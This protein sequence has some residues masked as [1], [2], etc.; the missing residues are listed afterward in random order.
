MFLPF[1]MCV[2]KWRHQWIVLKWQLCEENGCSKCVT[3]MFMTVS[4]PLLKAIENFDA[5][6]HCFLSSSKAV[7]ICPPWWTTFTSFADSKVSISPISDSSFPR[8]KEALTETKF[9]VNFKIWVS[10]TWKRTLYW[11][12]MIR[13]YCYSNFISHA[14]TIE[15]LTVKFWVFLSLLSSLSAFFLHLAISAI[16]CDCKLLTRPTADQPIW[17]LDLFKSIIYIIECE[18]QKKELILKMP[19]IVLNLQPWALSLRVIS[20]PPWPFLDTFLM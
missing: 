4:P 13:K 5:I 19:D 14:G 15:L 9:F 10:P 20:T 7:F 16:D 6:V 18:T 2:D 11:Y 17:P 12:D 8:G 1:I 3:M